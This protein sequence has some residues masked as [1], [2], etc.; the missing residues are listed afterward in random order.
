MIKGSAINNDGANKVG[1]T[2]PSVQGQAEVIAEA[3]SMAEVSAETIQLVEAHGTGTPLGDPVEIEALT[4]VWQSQ[5]SRKGYCALG[6]VKGNVGHLGAASGIAGLIKATLALHHKQLPP[7][8]NFTRPNPN[9][10]FEQTPFYPH[11][12]LAPWGKRTNIHAVPRS[13]ASVWGNQRASDSGRSTEKS[14]TGRL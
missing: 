9:I 13:V 11:T 5:T 12:T 1:F 14:I 4:R 6:S 10:P 2:A 7:T 3:L 8:I